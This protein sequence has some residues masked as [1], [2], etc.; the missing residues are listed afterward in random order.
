[1]DPS[2]AQNGEIDP[3][4]QWQDVGGYG[5]FPALQDGQY[6]SPAYLSCAYPAYNAELLK[7][8]SPQMVKALK[9]KYGF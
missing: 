3:T 1:M 6:G 5:P 7:P 2:R 4:I 8:L 9:E